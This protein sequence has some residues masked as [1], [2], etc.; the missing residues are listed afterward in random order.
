MAAARLSDRV[1][2][3]PD[4]GVLIGGRDGAG[5][6]RGAADVQVGGGRA[7]G[8]AAGCVRERLPGFDL[9]VAVAVPVG[10]DPGGG[11]HG[12]GAL[13]GG[14]AGGF[15][16]RGGGGPGPDGGDQGAAG[17]GEG[18]VAGRDGL[19]GAGAFPEGRGDG[20]GRAGGGVHELGGGDPGGVLLADQVRGHRAQDR[21]GP[22]A[23]VVDGR[24]GLAQGGL[25]SVPPPLVGIGE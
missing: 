25:G 21:P 18:Q 9:V 11:D 13:V 8:D 5:S 23:G 4:R 7:G 3:V 19:A 22:R 2:R 16:E 6:G 15:G 24:L 20:G 12:Q 1:R 10:G 17:G 14:D